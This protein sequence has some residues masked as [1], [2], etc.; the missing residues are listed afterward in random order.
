MANDVLLKLSGLT[1]QFGGLTA[2]DNLDLEVRTGQIVSIIGPNGAGKT[3]VFNMI[4]G[5]YKPTAGTILFDGRPIAG[6]GPDQV[7][8]RGI[9]RTFQNIR[10]FNNMSVL[11]NVLVGQHT[12]FPGDL[13]SILLHLPN[14]RNAERAARARALE[15]LRFFGPEL[16]ARQDD[17]VLNLAY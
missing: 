14:Y 7:L 6:I 16:V 17:Y 2:V 15:L 9:A 12:T 8:R 4:T 10:L 5:I 13:P 1:Q 3:T 11:D